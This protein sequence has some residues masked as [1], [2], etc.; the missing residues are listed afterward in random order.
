MAF[1]SIIAVASGES[2]DA[3]VFAVAARFAVR[4]GAHLQILPA[5]PDPAAD[6]VSYGAALKRGAKGPAAERVAASE[7]ERQQSIE[8]LATEAAAREGL[9]KQ[10][11]TVDQRA[12]QPVVALAPAAMLADLVLLGAGGARG[13]LAGL[14]AETLISHRAPC[15]L[16]KSGDFAFGPAAVAWDGSAQAARALK[17]ALP[18][19][20]KASRVFVLHN[21][22]DTNQ[23]PEA[24]NS[25]QLI[26]YLRL[27]DVTNVETR[28]ARGERVAPSLLAAARAEGCELL[29]AGAYGRPRLYE[30]VLGGT[31][32]ALADAAGPPHVLLAH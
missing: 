8:A 19:L 14:F 6:L 18:L 22:E 4:F 26:A 5:F 20:Q 30:L 11:L 27:H 31:T 7:R 13:S 9:A 12:L 21:T 10:A 3:Q 32:R 17:G 15:L 25:A 23:D 24:A 1:R 16:I 2:E 29:V 28:E